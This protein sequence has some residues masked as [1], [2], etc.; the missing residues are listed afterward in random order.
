MYQFRFYANKSDISDIF[1]EPE[2]SKAFEKAFMSNYAILLNRIREYS[3][4]I[5]SK[6]NP[7]TGHSSFSIKLSEDEIISE[8]KDD[9]KR[10]I[11]HKALKDVFSCKLNVKENILETLRGTYIQN[12]IM[13]EKLLFT[14]EKA[15]VDADDSS[16]LVSDEFLTELES[17]FLQK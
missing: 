15:I 17:E 8:F 1:K 16:V 10:Y 12:C 7:N 6:N 9:L 2:V 4:F 5:L 11:F 14:F 3:N 13:G